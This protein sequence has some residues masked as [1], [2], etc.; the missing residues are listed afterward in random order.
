MF[1]RNSLLLESGSGWMVL[2]LMCSHRLSFSSPCL[3][4]GQPPARK[5][6]Q[7]WSS[8]AEPAPQSATVMA[9]FCL[10]YLRL[11]WHSSVSI[12]PYLSAW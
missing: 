4:Y 5:Y 2:L 10:L 1:L 9:W 3:P 8:Q 12:F 11:S 6:L 7:E